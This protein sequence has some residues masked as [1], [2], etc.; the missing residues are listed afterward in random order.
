MELHPDEAYYWVWSRH[1]QLSYFDHPPM[2]AYFIKLTTLFSTSEFFVRFSGILVSLAISLIIWSLSKQLFSDEKI[3]AGSV[4]LLNVYP[5]TMSG[6]VI[7]TP[8]VPAFLFLALA[9]FCAWQA[10]KPDKAYYWYI[11]SFFFGLA[12][13]SKYTAVLLL[14]CI[15]LYMFSTDERRH[16]RSVHPYL[17]FLISAALF[18]PVIIWNVGNGWISFKFQAGHGLSGYDSFGGILEYLGGQLLV[19]SPFAWLFG[20]WAAAIFCFTRNKAKLYVGLTSLP[21]I[22]F[23]LLTSFKHAAAPNWPVLAYFT[24]TLAF[25]AYFLDGNKWKKRLWAFA[26]GFSFLFSLLATAHARFSV[27]PLEKISKEWVKTDATNWFYGWKELA[28]KIREYPQTRYVF[29][30]SHT[31]SATIDYY[32]N[33]SGAVATVYSD[34]GIGRFSQ[35]NLWKMPLVSGAP[36]LYVSLEGE[37]QG[38]YKRY[39]EGPVKTDHLL[40][41]RKGIPVR[42]FTIIYGRI[43]TQ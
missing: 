38:A 21:I 36:A 18:L 31:L 41:Y 35:Y 6:S 11:F 37:A 3:A 27:M 33:R 42:A 19:L 17:S 40:I 14:P 15:F 10:F 39:F 13:L 43:K 34:T 8:D 4:I 23:F 5:L 7:I 30:P 2:V 22:L 25:C 1:L 9:V 16:L 12:L 20:L 24:F 26:V 29:S 32:L 28:G